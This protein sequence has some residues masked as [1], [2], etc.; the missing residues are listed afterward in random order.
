MSFQDDRTWFL[1]N[2]KRQMHSHNLT[3]SIFNENE[4]TTRQERKEHERNNKK[5]A[6]CSLVSV[7]CWAHFG[8]LHNA[9]NLMLNPNPPK[10]VLHWLSRRLI[11]FVLQIVFFFIDCDSYLRIFSADVGNDA[12]N[13]FSFESREIKFETRNWVICLS[14][15]PVYV[16]HKLEILQRECRSVVCM[17][18]EEEEEKGWT[19]GSSLDV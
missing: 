12:S 14:T 11:I 13:T 19:D 3:F 6:N 15:S 1:P 18:E 7:H 8:D 10:R 4:T 16:W 5:C 2:T 9:K 17:S